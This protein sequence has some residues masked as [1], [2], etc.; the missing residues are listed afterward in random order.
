MLERSNSNLKK[1]ETC[2]VAYMKIW[3]VLSSGQSKILK[4]R[5]QNFNLLTAS[6]YLAHISFNT[7]R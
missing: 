4:L 5:E 2:V 1:I 6:W 3:D 7:V